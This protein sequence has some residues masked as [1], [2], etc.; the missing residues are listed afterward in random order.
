MSY[1]QPFANSAQK[2]GVVLWLRM[3][4]IGALVVGAVI[5]IRYITN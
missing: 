1:P 4:V 3:V 5:L 2:K